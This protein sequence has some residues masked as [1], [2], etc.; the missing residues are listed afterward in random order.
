MAANLGIPFR[1]GSGRREKERSL[2]L[3]C[4]EENEAAVSK[5]ITVHLYNDGINWKI[6]MDSDIA[7]AVFGDIPSAIGSVSQDIESNTPMQAYGAS[8]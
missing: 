6:Q 5:D 3:S 7:G 1:R 8:N 2:L 4:I